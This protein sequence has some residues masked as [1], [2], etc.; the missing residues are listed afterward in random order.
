[1]LSLKKKKEIK[2][3]KKSLLKSL[4]PTMEAEDSA[5]YSKYLNQILNDRDIKNNIIN[6]NVAVSGVYGAGKSSILKT[7][8]KEDSNVIYDEVK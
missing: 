2:Y 5:K 7:F 6:K 3:E 8:F 4:A 1:M